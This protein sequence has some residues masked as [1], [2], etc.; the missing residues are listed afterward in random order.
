MLA[1]LFLIIAIFLASSKLTQLGANYGD[2]LTQLQEWVA[3]MSQ[4]Y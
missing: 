4:P 2:Q 3:F 1:R